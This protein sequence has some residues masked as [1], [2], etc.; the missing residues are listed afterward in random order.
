M[1]G[2]PVRGT[3]AHAF[4]TSYCSISDLLSKVS[5]I[6]DLCPLASHLRGNPLSSRFSFPV[7]IGT[8]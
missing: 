3:H 4:I 8:L 7:A 1:F 2:I 6:A 5:V